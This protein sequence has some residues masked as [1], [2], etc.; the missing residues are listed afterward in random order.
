MFSAESMWLFNRVALLSQAYTSGVGMLPLGAVMSF[1]KDMPL[2]AGWL[3]TDGTWYQGSNYQN[4]FNN[5]SPSNNLSA[6]TVASVFDTDGVT[7]WTGGLLP[8]R[9]GSAIISEDEQSIFLPTSK[10]T[11]VR[12]QVTTVSGE[13]IL[14][15][16]TGLGYPGLS[17]MVSGSDGNFKFYTSPDAAPT[18]VWTDMTPGFGDPIPT[19]GGPE[20]YYDYGSGVFVFLDSSN[21]IWYWNGGSSTPQQ[22]N[23]QNCNWD[24]RKNAFEHFIPGTP[25]LQ[26]SNMSN[27][28]YFNGFSSGAEYCGFEV[29]ETTN[30]QRR[31]VFASDYNNWN[32]QHGEMSTVASGVVPG[33]NDPLGVFVNRNFYSGNNTYGPFLA[34]DPDTALTLT[35]MSGGEVPSGP[36]NATVYPLLPS[37]KSFPGYQAQAVNTIIGVGQINQQAVFSSGDD[38]M[39]VM[40]SDNFYISDTNGDTADGNQILIS[41]DGSSW[42]QLVDPSLVTLTPSFT[43]SYWGDTGD[44]QYRYVLMSNGVLM[45][46]DFINYGQFQVPNVTAPTGL[47][48]GIAIGNATFPL[49]GN[50]GGGG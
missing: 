34:A 21:N 7:P 41:R 14:G 28:Q 44:E 46:L 33:T 29:Q 12:S 13:T 18:A 45:L 30:Q 22:C 20:T 35:F 24:G 4:Y 10:T 23:P 19:L 25:Y 15:A 31:I 36:Y 38:S 17:V 43:F 39:R 26:T 9:D 49:P 3:P 47:V 32:Q 27:P 1:P 48:S 2:P 5:L 40:V 42:Y 8:V 50:N 37:S 6:L 16:A 11:F